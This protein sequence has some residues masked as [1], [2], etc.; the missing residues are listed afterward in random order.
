MV[1][2]LAKIALYSWVVIAFLAYVRLFDG[3]AQAFARLLG[4]YG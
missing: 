2:L 4:L 1:D 3:E